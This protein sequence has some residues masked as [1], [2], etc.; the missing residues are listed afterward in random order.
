LMPKLPNMAVITSCLR[1]TVTM[2]NLLAPGRS[3]SPQV[4]RRSARER[5]LDVGENV[6]EFEFGFV[7]FEALQ[8][9]AV[10]E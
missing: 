9:I 10:F 2:P 3:R 7:D 5:V 1:A 4:D 8:A 6:F